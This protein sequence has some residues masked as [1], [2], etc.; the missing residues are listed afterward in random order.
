MY[1]HDEYNTSARRKKKKKKKKKQTGD[2]DCCNGG[3]ASANRNGTLLCVY[4]L[5][6]TK[7]TKARDTHE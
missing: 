3:G 6:G 7:A 4:T 2:R 1:A 5:S